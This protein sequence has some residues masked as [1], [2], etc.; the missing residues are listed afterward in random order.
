MRAAGRSRNLQP[1]SRITSRPAGAG[2]RERTGPALVLVKP[3]PIRVVIADAQPVV[4]AGFTAMLECEEDIGVAGVAG[5]TDEAVTLARELRPHVALLA[6]DLPGE[7]G[8][9]TARRIHHHPD[10]ADVN[11][12]ILAAHDRDEDLF[13]ALHAGALGFVLKSSEPAELV[14]AVRVLADGEALLSPSATRRLIAE[15]RS[16]PRPQVPGPEQL[17]EL[18]ARE[19]E[20]MGLVAAG[21][22]NDEIADRFVI[23]PATVKTHVSRALR[24]LGARD[25][26]QLVAI[27]DQLGLVDPGVRAALR[28]VPAAPTTGA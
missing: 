26:S 7:G 21:L 17:D 1:V 6:L 2:A 12:V 9:E 27:A 14:Q 11:V 19:R 8:V 3:A 28:G 18:T 25:R 16:R 24:K 13:A 15:L 5:D 23:S 20:V 22:C 10:S 4:R